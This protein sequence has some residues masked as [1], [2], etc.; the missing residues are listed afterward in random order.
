MTG[1]IAGCLL[2]GALAASPQGAGGAQLDEA[3]ELSA[4]AGRISAYVK[5]HRR[6]EGP[7]PPPMAGN[8]MQEVYRLMAALRR[9]IRAARGAHGQG[10]LVTPQLAIVLRNVVSRT[11]TVDDLVDLDAELL[12]HTPRS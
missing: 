7:I 3:A 4:F 10:A 12:D 5:V 1:Y 6:L 8:D 2:L 9:A 11:L